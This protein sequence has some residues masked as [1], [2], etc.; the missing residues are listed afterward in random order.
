[1][2]DRHYPPHT[3]LLEGTCP[4]CRGPALA[5]GRDR[6]QACGVPQAMPSAPP[7]LAACPE[8]SHGQPGHICVPPGTARAAAAEAGAGS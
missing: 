1:M 7:R 3:A 6:C 4:G 5:A 2:T 8:R